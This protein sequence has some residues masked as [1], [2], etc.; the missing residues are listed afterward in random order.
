MAADDIILKLEEH[1]GKELAKYEME[2]TGED[3]KEAKTLKTTVHKHQLIK[4]DADPN[5]WTCGNCGNEGEGK[6]YHCLL[7]KYSLCKDCSKDNKE[8]IKTNCFLRY[9]EEKYILTDVV[10]SV[11]LPR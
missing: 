5:E 8:S 7:C 10:T 3:L 11:P 9:T 4:I 6:R 1:E 2:A